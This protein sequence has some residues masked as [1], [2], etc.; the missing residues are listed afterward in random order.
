MNRVPHQGQ[1][2]RG[3]AVPAGNCPRERLINYAGARRF[4]SR[5]ATR[6]P[7]AE[8]PW[9]VGDSRENPARQTR[10]SDRVRSQALYVSPSPR[11]AS[12]FL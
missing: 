7:W 1:G 2:V 4:Y 5:G 6:A 9:P 3:E 8:S 12:G 11:F 10:G